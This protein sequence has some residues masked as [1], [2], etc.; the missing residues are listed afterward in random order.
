MSLR[1]IPL[2]NTEFYHVF[3][4]GVDKRRI[5]MDQYDLQRFFQ[6]MFVFNTLEPIGSIYEH[7]YLK[8]FGS[9]ASKK[10]KN[11]KLVDF[12]CFCLNLN[13][14][15]FILRQISD[16]GIEKF[17]HRLSTG[18]TKY[19]NHKHQRSGVLFQG[20]FK[21]VHIDTNEQLLHVSA[22][23]NLNFKVHNFG[24]EASKN[25]K[26]L[27]SWDEYIGKSKFDFC[28]K[29]DILGQFKNK[30][31]YENFAKKTLKSISQK[32]EMLRELEE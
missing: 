26:P 25:F 17:M 19:F 21:A 29:N 22:Y 31:E 24:S 16:Q 8:K 1:R 6:S 12:G 20:P 13:H 11:K 30:K 23:V 14:Y 18:Y 28:Q 15:H 2:A 9:E 5:F 10:E 27:S 32:K 7:T 4:R 3:N